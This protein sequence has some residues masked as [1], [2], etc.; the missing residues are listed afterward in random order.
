MLLFL[1]ACDPPSVGVPPVE[2]DS[3]VDSEEPQESKPIDS[4]DT[5]TDDPWQEGDPLPYPDF[6]YDCDN[7]P[8]E[9]T[10]DTEMEGARAYHGM[11]F[12]DDGM[13]V[14]W[15]GRN[16]LTKTAYGEEYETFVPGMR[17]VEQIQRHPD[18]TMFM[19]M[20]EESAVYRVWPE[21]GY[22]RVAS[23]LYWGYGLELAPDGN[24][25]VADGNVSKLD[26][27]TGE[28][29]VLFEKPGNDSWLSHSLTINLDSTMLYVG[30][31]GDGF[32]YRAE[33]DEDLNPVGE[34]EPWVKTPG[35]WKDGLRFDACG[36]LW[37]A[38]Y[39]TS[40]LYRISPEGDVETFYKANQRGYG[41]GLVWGRTHG[42]WRSDALYLPLPYDRAKVRELVIG[43]PD[44]RLV[45]TWKGEKVHY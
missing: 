26:I 29:T 39:D 23:G 38:D 36:Y 33:L 3:T 10:S 8:T 12:D 30:G 14:G 44:G 31:I 2:T 17:G 37:A 4:E 1:L 16:S 43:V 40:S 15:D 27:E 19:I 13:L 41:H 9:P 45:R 11:A 32:I 20:V 21:G 7:L 35:Q 22:E 34:L 6:E 42:G 28:L 5:D 18:G 24:L 25:F